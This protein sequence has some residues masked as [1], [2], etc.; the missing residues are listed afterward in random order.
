MKRIMPVLT[1]TVL[2]TA[3]APGGSPRFADTDTL[4]ELA[5]RNIADIS[6]YSEVMLRDASERDIMS[7]ASEGILMQY[8]ERYGSYNGDAGIDSRQELFTA[9]ALLPYRIPQLQKVFD[10]EFPA[11]PE[12]YQRLCA[13]WWKAMGDDYSTAETMSNAIFTILGHSYR[14]ETPISLESARN[15]YHAALE[16]SLFERFNACF[17]G[18]RVGEKAR[19]ALIRPWRDYYRSVTVQGYETLTVWAAAFFALRRESKN[20]EK[21]FQSYTNFAARFAGEDF[22]VS[23]AFAMEYTIDPDTDECRRITGILREHIGL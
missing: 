4:V 1:I 2:L 12:G 6:G 14:S 8:Q 19:E 17:N 11:G 10:R 22:M 7:F 5:S 13:M 21:A 20:L 9:M 23:F 3:A 18:I 16:Y 15:Y